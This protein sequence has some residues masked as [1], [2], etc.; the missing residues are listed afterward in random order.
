MINRLDLFL[1]LNHK[2]PGLISIVSGLRNVLVSVGAILTI[3]HTAQIT[4]GG[5]SDRLKF[6]LLIYSGEKVP[7][8]KI[9][10]AS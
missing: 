8:S 4:Q 5:E 1:V 10:L 7:N 6:E 2:R 9:V 3:P